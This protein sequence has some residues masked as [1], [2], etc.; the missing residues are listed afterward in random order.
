VGAR[1]R[2]DA[3][4]RSPRDAPG[5]AGATATSD[6]EQARVVHLELEARSRAGAV[7]SQIPFLRVEHTV[8]QEPFDPRVVVEAPAAAELGGRA[9][10]VRKPE[11]HLH[12]DPRDPGLDPF[13]EPALER[14]RAV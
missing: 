5:T 8:E 7:R 14:P 6:L 4:R 1:A 9:G 12:L 11:P 10:D 13:G 3:P 2:P